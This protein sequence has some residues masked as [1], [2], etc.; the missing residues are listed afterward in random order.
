MLIALRL[1]D[2]PHLGQLSDQPSGNALD[3]QP[4]GYRGSKIGPKG[5]DLLM[6]LVALLDGLVALLEGCAVLRAK[7]LYSLA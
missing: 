1:K 6:C 7:S 4:L 5:A 2:P 3:L